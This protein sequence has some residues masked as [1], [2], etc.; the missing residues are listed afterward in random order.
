MNRLE[1]K[2]AVVTGSSRGIGKVIAESFLAEGASVYITGRDPDRLAETHSELSGTYGEK[3]LSFQGDLTDPETIIRLTHTVESD[4]KRLDIVVANI[5]TGRYPSGWM[6]KDEVWLESLQTNLMAAVRISR[7]A[8]A[9]MQ[10]QHS[11]VILV[12]SSIAGVE[13]I[14]A[15][16]PY[17]VAKA[18]LLQYVN[19]T[20]GC[21]TKLGIRINAIS[22]GNVCFKGSTWDTKWRE[23]PEPVRH[24]IG[25]NVPM[26]RFGSPQE[27]AEL[28]CFLVSDSASFITGSNFV[29]DGGQSRVI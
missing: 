11:G 23:D 19:Y 22:P 25:Q 3:V 2:I 21:I 20:A 16:V 10:R 5:G 4:Q 14:A 7:E 15:P 9:V 24:Y 8:I 1:G 18:A 12:I 6:V 13:R 27:I 28:A 17:A 29:I 26:Q